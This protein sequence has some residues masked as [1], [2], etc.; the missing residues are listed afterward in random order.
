MRFYFLCLCE[1]QFLKSYAREQFFEIIR[2]RSLSDPSFF[3]SIKIFRQI[4]TAQNKSKR[5][6][7]R[8][9]RP[10]KCPKEKPNSTK[11][12]RATATTETLSQ[13]S[14][15]DAEFDLCLPPHYRFEPIG[16]DGPIDDVTRR[17]TSRMTSG[18]WN[19]LHSSSSVF[20]NGRY[21]L[22]NQRKLTSICV[23]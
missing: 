13:R 20:I 11:K 22:R 2:A 18:Q 5:Q 23:I 3:M 1:E 7:R 10:H 21:R 4:K 8:N 9:R 15:F 16:T 12:P 19:I 17:S 6:R 14:Q